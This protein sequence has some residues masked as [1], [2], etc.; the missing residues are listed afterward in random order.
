MSQ[1][2]QSHTPP[3]FTW[4]S[5]AVTSTGNVRSHN[6]DAILELPAAG[7]WVVA[8]GMGG[9]NA[10]D[11]ASRMVVESLAT[12]SATPQPSVFLDAVEDRLREVNLR[13][14]QH[15]L[16]AETGVSG[17]TVAALL[18]FDRFAL[19][20]WAGDSRVYRSRGGQCEQVTRD[21]SEVQE[22]LDDGVVNAA[23][24][25]QH[26]AANVI[27][28]A[29]GGMEQLYLDLELRELRHNDRFLV[30]SDGLYKEV[31]DDL[32][33][34]HLAGNDPEGACKALLKH[35]LSGKGSDN[36]SIVV[37]QFLEVRA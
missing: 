17:S 16:N 23:D 32:I 27:T 1:A 11:V 13:L 33:G 28:R 30:C 36:V 19:S 31:S 21:H 9:H 2:I 26:S 15:S 8:D 20:V 25:E 18:A 24:A 6:E 29:V 3:A 10:G 35:A 12:V 34:R 37:V 7:L 4:K 5:A 22:M 14:Y